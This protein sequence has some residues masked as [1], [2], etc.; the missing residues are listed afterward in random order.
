MTDDST[1]LVAPLPS[2]H[3]GQLEEENDTVILHT[4]DAR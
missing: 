4:Q 2:S 3:G 1:R